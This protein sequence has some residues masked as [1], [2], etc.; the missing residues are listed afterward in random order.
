MPA[1]CGDLCRFESALEQ[2]FVGQGM[3]SLRYERSM[4]TRGNKD[5]VQVH[6]VPVSQADT[7]QAIPAFMQAASKYNLKFYEIQV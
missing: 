3:T 2:M 5:H 7:R 6:V 1:A 4:R